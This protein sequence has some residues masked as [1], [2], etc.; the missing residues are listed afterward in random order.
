MWK[1]DNRFTLWCPKWCYKRRLFGP[2]IM[3]QRGHALSLASVLLNSLIIGKYGTV[4]HDLL[5]RINYAIPTMQYIVLDKYEQKWVQWTTTW[6]Q[7]TVSHTVWP[8][9]EYGKTHGFCSDAVA[10]I[11]ENLKFPWCQL[12]RHWWYHRLDWQPAAP[13]VTTKLA[14]WQLLVFSV[15]A[16]RVPMP[17]KSRY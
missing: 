2:C 10:T 13:P 3:V 14:L 6:I 16:E 4:C 5:W 11:T 17:L 15:D 7:K 1:T 8:L 9:E 12:H